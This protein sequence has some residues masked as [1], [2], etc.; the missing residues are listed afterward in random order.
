MI[1]FEELKDKPVL[2]FS[3]LCQWLKEKGCSDNPKDY[4]INCF[5]EYVIMMREV[6]VK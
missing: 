1:S 6:K 5:I 2:K 4:F 3:E